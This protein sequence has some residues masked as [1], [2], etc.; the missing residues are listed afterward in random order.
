M[1]LN[2]PLLQGLGLLGANQTGS[3]TQ[4]TEN[5][6][7]QALSGF[8]GQGQV[9]NAAQAAQSGGFD[10]SQFTNNIM[11][12]PWAPI[13]SWGGQLGGAL[14]AAANAPAVEALGQFGQ[15]LGQSAVVSQI[16]NQNNAQ[17]AARAATILDA[18]SGGQGQTQN[19]GAQN[20]LDQLRNAAG[21]NPTGTQ[22][23]GLVTPG[24]IDL[25]NRPILQNDN[26]TVSTVESFGTNINGQEVLLPQISPDGQR[27]TKEE[28]VQNYLTTGQHLGIFDSP[29]SASA[30]GKALSA[31]ERE[32]TQ[33]ATTTISNGFG[34]T[35]TVP[36]QYRESLDA[37]S[38]FLR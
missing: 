21:G 31:R 6:I 2:I 5:P 37:L 14:G 18:L 9:G 35:L 13:A 3:P 25:S 30:Y 8:A 28:A 33:G 23:Q 4:A 29:E 15:D 38:K 12:S 24:N 16:V 17:E 20:I 27:W 22:I 10:V 7:Q 34:S 1:A 32:R 19:A 11:N 36:S 26:G